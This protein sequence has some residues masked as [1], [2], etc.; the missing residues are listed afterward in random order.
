VLTASVPLAGQTPTTQNP[1]PTYPPD[2]YPPG[3]Y[4]PNTYPT[5]IPGGPTIGIPIPEIKFPKRSGKEKEEKAKDDKKDKD[6]K[7][8]LKPIDGTLRKIGEKDLLLETSEKYV[9]RFR[10]LAKTQFRDQKG[11][12]IRDSLLKPGDQLSVEVNQDDEETALRVV[13]VR[14]GTPAERAAATQPVDPASIRLSGDASVA[15]PAGDRPAS[16]NASTAATPPP[17]A[18]KG[19][20]VPP[21]PERQNRETAPSPG[22]WQDRV[23]AIPVPDG[24]ETIAA[25]REAAESFM[26][27]LPDFL[28]QQETTRCYSTARPPRWRALDV[29]RAD[30][31]CV[32]GQEEYR[33]V[34]I[35]GKPARGPVEQTGSWSTG[36][37]AI[38]LQDV[39]SPISA[40][41]FVK[42]A[43]QRIASRSAAVYDYTVQQDN[44]HWRIVEPGGRS[45]NP[46][47]KGSIWIDKETHRVLRIEQLA[48][49]T[50]SDFPY[51]QIEATLE[52][53]FVP[54]DNVM[55]LLPVRSEGV[56]CSR[57]GM[58]CSR[59]AMVFRNYRK[60]AVDS[61]V[62]F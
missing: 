39:L 42:R 30:V 41:K 45:Y 3:Q 54:I 27:L 10:L 50:P 38:T 37:F 22:E 4:P 16:Q 52:Y 25:A 59:N 36:E 2:T 9:L 28:V 13:L 48:S 17:P 23:S 12:S 32:N 1:P 56:I 40:A 15:G 49:S 57:G 7:V 53:D 44:S 20:T 19:G 21:A 51:D 35:N 26:E 6:L 43:E 24:D 33:N 14:A 34:S 29:V 8:T 62:K 18:S 47:Y 55:F 31:A 58:G 61:K 5:R 11:E 46:A 60:F